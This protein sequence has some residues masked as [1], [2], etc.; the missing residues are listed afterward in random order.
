MSR[1]VQASVQAEPD[2]FSDQQSAGLRLE[3]TGILKTD[4]QLRCRPIGDDQH[5]VPVLCLDLCEVGGTGRTL[6]AQQIF[7]EATR[8]HAEALTH[9][10]TKG[11]RVTLTTSLLDIRIFLPHVERI[12]L[13][14]TPTQH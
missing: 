6:L 10:L 4:A 2:M 3:F 7:S 13:D 12:Q 8:K 1:A 11:R 14:A 5:I 9:T